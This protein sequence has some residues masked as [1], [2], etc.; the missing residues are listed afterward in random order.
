MDLVERSALVA[1]S[2]ERMCALVEDIES[3]P[4][5]LPWC[6]STHVRLRDG[7]R[8]IASLHIEYRGVRQAFTT[9]NVRTGHVIAM[10]LVDG[11]FRAL[12]GTW[13]FAPLGNDACKVEL[14]L[15]YQLASPMLARLIGPVF[16]GIAN[17][18]VDS[19]V[20]RAATVYA[21]A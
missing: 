12:D 7:G 1:H 21:A 4:R 15:A 2:A 16:D 20:L 6:R 13:R 11:P 9:E 19:F 5:F 3:Y 10:R 14:L 8:M 18:M 17:T